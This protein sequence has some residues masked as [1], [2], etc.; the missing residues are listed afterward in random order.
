V[1]KVRK[2]IQL[3]LGIACIILLL[4]GCF[5]KNAN[6]PATGTPANEQQQTKEP[7][8][9]QPK[10]EQG[11]Q[12][13]QN[14]TKPAENADNGVK[15][16]TGTFTGQVDSN[17]I[18]IK[19]SGVPEPMSFKVFMLNDELKESFA[20]LKINEGDTVKFTYTVNDKQQSVISKIE[21]I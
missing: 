4:A 10:I 3:I 11:D 21:K 14:P 7:N 20:Q 9:V 5:S 12:E 18:E 13:Q 17:F 2:P 19:L 16:D 1:F 6:P 15:T 8:N